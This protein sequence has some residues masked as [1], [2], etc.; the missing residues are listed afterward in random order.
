VP[1]AVFTSLVEIAC[2]ATTDVIGNAKVISPAVT[3][4]ASEI[5]TAVMF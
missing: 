3:I 1:F 2:E 5:L 4:R